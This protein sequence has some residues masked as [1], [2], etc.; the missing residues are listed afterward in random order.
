M[1][2]RLFKKVERVFELTRSRVPFA[3]TSLLNYQY[4]LFKFLDLLHQFELLHRISL[5]ETHERLVALHLRRGW[6]DLS[7]NQAPTIGDV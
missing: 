6:L 7:A 4:F 5:L 3:R 2:V 1:M